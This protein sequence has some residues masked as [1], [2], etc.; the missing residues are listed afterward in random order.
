[1]L[2]DQYVIT[3]DLTE[4]TT[5]LQAQTATLNVIDT[6]T[7]SGFLTGPQ[8]DSAYQTWLKLGN[9]GTQQDFINSLVPDTIGN[10]N[11]I[12]LPV[13]DGSG[14]LAIATINPDM[15]WQTGPYFG[16]NLLDTFALEDNTGYI[17]TEDSQYYLAQQS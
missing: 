10:G 16:S 5:G 9:T 1:M 15:S 2:N 8:G 3:V 7:T 13:N 12:I 17:I 11:G 6:I 4:S 14:I